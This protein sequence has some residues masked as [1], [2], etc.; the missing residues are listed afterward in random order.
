LSSSIYSGLSGLRSFE[1]Y[2]DVI[3]NNI[4]NS[5]T[6][7]YRGSR[8]TFGDLLSITMP[9]AAP[10]ASI[11][12]RNPQQIGLGVGVKSI[13]LN[14]NT[15]SLLATGR[16]LDL[17]VLGP[18]LFVVNDGTRDL[19][20]RAGSFG[21]DGVGTLVDLG[22]GFQVRSVTGSSIVVPPNALSA[23]NA[24]ANVS[25]QGNLPA[26]MTGP[27]AEVLMS[28]NPYQTGTAAEH[29]GTGSQPFAFSDGD[30]FSVEVD[31][32]PAQIVV[33]TTAAFTNIG[34][35]IASATAAEVAQVINDQISGAT[36]A[37][38]S[39]AVQVASDTIGDASSLKLT[40]TASTPLTALG[41]S[42]ALAAG[43]QTAALP[44][45][46]LNDLTINSTDYVNGDAITVSGTLA[47]NT[48][49]SADFVYGTDGTT[50]ED[51]RAF[52]AA[53]LP[54]ATVSIDNQGNLV[55]TANTVGEAQYSLLLEDA[56][57]NTGATNFDETSFVVDQEGTKPDEVSTG[58]SIFDRNGESHVLNLRFQRVD[59]QTW[60]LFATLPNDPGATVVDG[61]VANIRFNQQGELIAAGQPG[62]DTILEFQFATGLQQ[63]NLDLGTLGDIDGVT[64]FGG[65]ATA[66][67]ISQDGYA[68]GTLSDVVVDENGFVTGIFTNGQRTAY[69]QI[70]LASFAN[71]EGLEKVGENMFRV[72]DNSGVAFV[73]APGGPGG[74]IQAGLLESS[75]VDLAEEFVRIIEAQRGYQAS[76]RVI[77]ASEELLQAL[78]QQI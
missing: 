4:A 14:T 63:V 55:A 49:F 8:V 44:T 11:G 3:G 40:N 33:F 38:V 51:L 39:G 30:A 10:T 72:A 41:L 5:N 15:G 23:P 62:A 26:T 18:G 76:A 2:L 60:E 74:R 71:A 64:H 7:G 50:L 48:P 31:G 77:R 52:I 43:T 9:G 1:T 17:T 13:D 73:S 24:T 27:L 42:T 59:A 20:T 78:L 37:A 70:G 32:G 21:F 68:A 66:N 6:S 75:N 22:S 35:N 67:A 57:T 19:Y 29:T 34:A 45:T 28:L 69:G 54:D 46:D 56:P 36:A 65:P 53:Q 58:I 61:H 12:G 47:D 16:N 25:L